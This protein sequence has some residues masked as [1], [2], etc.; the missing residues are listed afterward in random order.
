MTSDHR[1]NE[2]VGEGVEDFEEEANQ[3]TH[4]HT[5]SC[6]CL[7]IFKHYSSHIF[8]LANDMVILYALGS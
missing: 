1:V 4:T 2:R 5:W 3:G 7:F 6:K 8:M